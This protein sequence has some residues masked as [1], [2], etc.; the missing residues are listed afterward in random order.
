MMKK[1]IT[2][3]TEAILINRVRWT[4]SRIAMLSVACGMTLPLAATA[5]KAPAASITEAQAARIDNALLLQGPETPL[6]KAV[7]E[8]R[9]TI[10][11]FLR[12]HS[13]I[14]YDAGGLNIFAA[15]GKTYPN[16][17]YAQ[18]PKPQMRRHDKSACVTVLR[19]H[20]WTMPSPNTLRF[21]VVYTSDNSGESGKSTHE[22]QKQANGEWLFSR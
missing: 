6:T 8:A 16:N 4:V 13:C 5:Q 11:A 21:E 19:V 15:P 18:S 1:K 17:N 12:V 7:A 3:K 22:V 2:C 10:A 14:T 20:G 9:S